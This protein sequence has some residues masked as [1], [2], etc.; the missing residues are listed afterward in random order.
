MRPIV[1]D[2]VARSVCLSATLVS[3]AKTAAPIEMPFGLWTQM[4]RRNHLL[5]GGPGVLRDVVMATNLGLELLLTGFVWTTTTRQLLME[6]VWVVGQQKADITDT[7]HL[8]DVAMATIFGFLYMGCTLAP[9]CEYDWTVQVWRRCGLMSNYFDHLF[10][11][12]V[13]ILY[14]QHCNVINI[15]VTATLSALP[16]HPVLFVICIFLCSRL[17]LCTN[18]KSSAVAEMGDRV[19]AKWAKKW[20]GLLCPF[21]CGSWVPT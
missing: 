11:L 4:G 12:S 20:R 3:P 14:V 16:A 17:F 9:P 18:N 15:L 10:L 1:T 2:R 13:I 6:G 21:P 8:R 19:R 5:D 7:L